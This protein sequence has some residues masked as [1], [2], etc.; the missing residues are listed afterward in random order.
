LRQPLAGR[1]QRGREQLLGTLAADLGEQA[2]G[3]ERRE[4]ELDQAFA[5]DGARSDFR[6][7]C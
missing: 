7:G 4:P 2:I 5:R 6:S 1:P 3:L